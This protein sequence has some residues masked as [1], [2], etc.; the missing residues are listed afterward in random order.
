MMM[1]VDAADAAA[2]VEALNKVGEK[3]SIVGEIVPNEGQDVI[4]NY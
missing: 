2:V 4:I 3:A 1:V